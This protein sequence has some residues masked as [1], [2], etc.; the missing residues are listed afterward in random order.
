M[1]HHLLLIFFIAVL[2]PMGCTK[3]IPSP[4]Y[5]TE[6]P[7]DKNTWIQWRAQETQQSPAAT[8]DTDASFQ[9]DRKPP[10][11]GAPYQKREG[12]A[13]WQ[14]HC[15][16]CHGPLGK[17]NPQNFEPSPKKLGG[18]GL[19]MGFFF[20]GDKMRAGIFHKI[21][22]GKSLKKPAPGQMPPFSE[23][24]SQEQIW[25]LVLHLENI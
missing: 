20:G 3:T 25:A 1:K 24:L 5:N 10:N 17:T 22:T 15:A 23:V 7:H 13:L 12:A 18:M 21:Q 19:K 6:F 11:Y 14:L 8:Q 2:G 9:K 4:Q 16:S